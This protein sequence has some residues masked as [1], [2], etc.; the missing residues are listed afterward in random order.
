MSLDR[1]TIT[2]ADDHTD[3]MDL[4]EISREFPFVEWGLLASQKR[5]SLSRFPALDWLVRLERLCDYKGADLQFSLHLCG[6]WLDDLLHGVP[7]LPA[8]YPLS[9]MFSRAQL[10]FHG[11]KR[12]YSR[13]YLVDALDKLS[14]KEIIF[15]VDG[16][17][18]LDLLAEVDDGRQSFDCVPLFDLSHGAGVLPLAWPSPLNSGVYHGY[19]GGLGP[20]NLAEQ[21]PLI[22]KAAAGERYWIDMET[23]VRSDDG[24]VLDLAKVRRCLQIA[25]P[26][27]E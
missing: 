10:N 11:K 3:P 5:S 19:A 21:I 24:I 13:D 17:M 12:S 6:Q 8:W 7:S 27:I 4:I 18:G 1:V 16:A 25:A 20:D 9:G 23:K 22:E 2:G 26:F 14:I 15:Q